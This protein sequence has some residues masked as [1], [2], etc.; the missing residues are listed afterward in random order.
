VNRESQRPASE[1]CLSPANLSQV[2]GNK[3][4]AKLDNIPEE[5]D[6]TPEVRIIVPEEPD[7]IPEKGN[8]VP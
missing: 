3:L 5:P 2:V 4:T 6:K 1:F 8:S 7:S